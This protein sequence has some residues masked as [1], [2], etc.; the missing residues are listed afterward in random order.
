MRVPRPDKDRKGKIY[1]CL[2]RAERSEQVAYKEFKEGYRS[3]PDDYSEEY[4]TS[5]FRDRHADCRPWADNVRLYHSIEGYDRRPM[6]P[7]LSLEILR[8]CRQTYQEANFVL[9]TA[10]TFCFEGTH[11]LKHFVHGLS[12][13]QK[14]MLKA[15]H[16]NKHWLGS[17]EDQ[18]SWTTLLTRAFLHKLS[19]LQTLHTTFIAGDETDL[20]EPLCAFKML[21]LKEVTAVFADS[22]S[23]LHPAS[24]KPERWTLETKRRYAEQFCAMVLDSKGHENFAA[25]CREEAKRK[26][27]SK[28]EVRMREVTFEAES[29]IS[30]LLNYVASPFA[31]FIEQKQRPLFLGSA[32]SFG[33]IPHPNIPHYH[34]VR[35]QAS[36]SCSSYHNLL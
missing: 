11:S 26:K 3:I 31:N 18:R 9:W 30:L 19:G 21:P 20:T 35:F 17:T 15:I 36:P 25:K 23:D 5:T 13:T 4:Y 29:G 7:R 34:S 33:T 24:H 27:I 6:V 14:R 16:I 12:A 32:S 2:C 28:E 1:Y 22:P 10:N 8:A